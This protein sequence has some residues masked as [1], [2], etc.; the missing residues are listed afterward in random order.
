[1]ARNHESS[2]LL[3]DE[4]DITVLFGNN[5]ST[6]SF[7]IQAIGHAGKDPRDKK[8]IELNFRNWK[9]V[10][11]RLTALNIFLSI[12]TIISNL[13]MLITLPLFSQSLDHPGHK[14]DEYPVLL[15]S[16][17]WFPFFF[18]GLIA[19]S[20][21]LD[22]DMVLKST[23]SHRVMF[24][25]GLLNS[26]NGLLVVYASDPSRTSP[27]LQAILGTSLIPFTVICRYILLRK[28]NPD[29]NAYTELIV[30][31]LVYVDRGILT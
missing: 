5:N 7:N 22:P 31:L 27:Q 14:T 30:I 17:L 29:I 15:F 1:M 19:I 13:M 4:T 24:I 16:S 6:N 3:V 9:S 2:P 28:G 18:F 10:R 8:Y 21:F 23:V 20:K 11:V 12:M 25:T 26:L